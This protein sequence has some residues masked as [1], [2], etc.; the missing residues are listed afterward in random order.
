MSPHGLL[1]TI[2]PCGVTRGTGDGSHTGDGVPG[3]PS[4]RGSDVITSSNRG[5]SRC[6]EAAHPDGE[7]ACAP[8][9]SAA[10][11]ADPQCA[12]AR[13]SAPK[14]DCRSSTRCIPVSVDD[15]VPGRMLLRGIAPACDHLQAAAVARERDIEPC[16]HSYRDGLLRPAPESFARV[17]PPAVGAPLVP[18]L[19]GTHLVML[20]ETG[21]L[22]GKV[23][24]KA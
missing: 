20:T 14:R 13:L 11:S 3:N 22:V 10:P 8:P 23:S 1:R 17:R 19:P 21:S 15:L 24:S 2:G 12:L 7:A 6:G 16:S 9:K 4:P 5:G 18:D